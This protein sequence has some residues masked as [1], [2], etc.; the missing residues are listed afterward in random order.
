MKSVQE[1]RQAL[2][3]AYPVWPRQT[4]AEHFDTVVKKYRERTFILTLE[5]EYSYIEIQERSDMLARGLLALGI[6]P[7][8]HVALL[9]GNYPEFIICKLA[10]AKIGAVCVPLNTMLL[11]YEL[12]F[13][14]EDADVVLLIYNDIFGKNNYLEIV[15]RLISG[16]AAQQPDSRTVSSASLPRLRNVVCFSADNKTYDDMMSFDALYRL[17]ENI[18]QA[19]LQRV[20]KDTAYPDDIMDIMY[21]SGTTSM[22]KGVMLS[23]DMLL[24]DGFASCFTR[25]MEDGRRFYV[26]LPL[27]HIFA[28]SVGLLAVTFVGGVFIT[29][30]YFAPG[31]ALELMEK[32]RANDILCVPTVMLALI[33]HPDLEKYDLSSLYAAVSGAASGPL[34]LWQRAVDKLGLQELTTGYGMTEVSG[35][36]T[37]NSPVGDPIEVQATRV[38]RVMIS[39]CSGVPEYGNY[40]IQYK[41]I[42]PDTGEELP[43]GTEG[44]WVCRG[45]IVTRGYYKRPQENADLIDKDGWLRTGDLGII[46]PDGLLQITG[47]SKDIYKAFGENVSPQ[48]VEDLI[49]THPKVNQVHVVGIPDR[50]M[51]ETGVAFIELRPGEKST[52]REIIEHCK[53]KLARFKIPRQVFFISAAELPVTSSG[54]IKKYKLAEMAIALLGKNKS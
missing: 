19:E 44:E 17:G 46:H 45:N 5:K 47:R 40:N 28:F 33:N 4:L 54:K 15:R 16:D 10:L 12:A 39:N 50:N 13:L 18:S 37:I 51:G 24:C 49:S 11:E 9:L 20:R 29:H 7:R 2:Q 23:H 30:P 1:R 41:V 36:S 52:R 6:K 27:Y 31:I 32:S 35:A 43:P 48:E 21:T 14:L 34:T 42:D 25:A 53:G 3:D 26:P 22:P 8:E 38:G